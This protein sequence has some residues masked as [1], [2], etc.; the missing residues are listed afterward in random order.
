MCGLM[1]A[2]C[3]KG[4]SINWDKEVKVMLSP[5]LLSIDKDKGKSKN[6]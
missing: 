5:I 4:N 6:K 2:L 1:A 3:D